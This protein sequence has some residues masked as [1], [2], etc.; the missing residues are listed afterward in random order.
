MRTAEADEDATLDPAEH[1]VDLFPWR[2]MSYILYILIKIVPQTYSTVHPHQNRP[3]RT[4]P[5][6]GFPPRTQRTRH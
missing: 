5:H 1:V 6:G 2:K 3:P 4:Q